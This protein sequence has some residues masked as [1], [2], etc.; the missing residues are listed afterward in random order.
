LKSQF[1]V[2]FA[3]NVFQTQILVISVVSNLQLS[4]NSITIFQNLITSWIEEFLLNPKL[5]VNYLKCSDILKDKHQEKKTILYGFHSLKVLY[6][7]ID[8]NICSS[9]MWEKTF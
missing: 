7:K 1:S 9:L 3:E 8:T 5:D 4:K 6:P 2:K